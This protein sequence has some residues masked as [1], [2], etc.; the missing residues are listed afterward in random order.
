MFVLYVRKIN[1]KFIQTFAVISIIIGI[2][3]YMFGYSAVSHFTST[4]IDLFIVFVLLK[5]F[6]F[7][8][9][10]YLIK[11]TLVLS[12]I[13]FIFWI[14]VNLS[15]DLHEMIPEIAG[16][17][18]LDPIDPLINSPE[19]ILVFTYEKQVTYGIIRNAGFCH[20]PGAYGVIL[21]YAIVFGIF[22]DKKLFSKRNVFFIICLL[23]TLSTAN[24]IALFFILMFHLFYISRNNAYISYMLIPIFIG[25]VILIS[26]SLSFMN[27]KINEEFQNQTKESLNTETAGRILG[28][29]KA[30]F[31]LSKYPLSGRGFNTASQVTD[32]ASPEAA[33]YGFFTYASQ[34][35]LL[36]FFISAILFK[37]TLFFWGTNSG[38]R[39]EELILL[40]LAFLPILFSQEFIPSTLF[41]MVILE[42][43]YRNYDIKLFTSNSKAI[44][45]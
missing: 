37:R 16:D 44:R 43:F 45:N 24:F 29:R 40:S 21:V 20:E 25:V 38:F 34:V 32:M 19:Q 27:D 10:K 36:V 42:T 41:N 39:K 22:L 7:N 23:S 15:P 26:S 14:A 12:I 2:Q 8:Y 18:G 17:Y 4:F 6:P 30:I 1:I 3:G 5:I 11:V 13:S 31:V 35:G 28:A 9:H 33:G